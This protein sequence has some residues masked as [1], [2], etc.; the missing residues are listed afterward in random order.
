LRI[1]GLSVDNSFYGAK[2]PFK[3]NDLHHLLYIYVYLLPA[4]G[5]VALATLAGGYATRAVTA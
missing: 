3:I 1:Y 2:K 5:A 4:A